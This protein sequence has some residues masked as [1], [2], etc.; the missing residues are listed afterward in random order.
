MA[1]QLHASYAELENKV[2]VRT[3]DLNEALKQQTVTADVLKVI[4]RTAF[5]LEAVL[6]TLVVSAAR[7]CEADR[8]CIFQRDGELYHWVSNFGFSDELASYARSHPFSPGQHSITGRVAL[9][10]RTIHSP[11]V[12]ADPSYTASEYQRLGNFRTMLGVPLL[13]EGAPIGVFILARDTVRPFTDHQVQ[14]VQSFA[15]QAVIAIENVRLFEQ[16]QA[17]TR[18][19]ASSLEDL[20]AT[21][22]RLIQSEKMASLGQLTA[23]SAHEI[24]NPLNFVNNFASLSIELLEGPRRAREWMRRRWKRSTRSWRRSRSTSG[25][26][27]STDG[28]PTGS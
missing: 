16:V 11:D 10:G 18:E 13:R 20:R 28:G 14:L 26:S 12:L 7:V 21:Q 15:D 25:R 17:R 19:L 24:K 22:D 8:A 27:A 4:S 9:E 2:E 3:R 1:G 6:D 5:D 23:G